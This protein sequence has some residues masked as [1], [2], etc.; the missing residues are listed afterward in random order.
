[1]A[2]PPAHAIHHLEHVMGTVVT[3][4]VYTTDGRA[5]AD[6]FRQLATAR[7]LLQRAHAVFSTWNPHSAVSRLRRGEITR[8]QA[9]A[10]VS[11][12]L[13]QCAMALNGSRRWTEHFPFAPHEAA[14][15]ASPR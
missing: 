13:E 6:L 8:G 1:V 3:I 12:V 4:D 14:P 15:S 7:E 2:A 5:G 9:P 11:E 10:E